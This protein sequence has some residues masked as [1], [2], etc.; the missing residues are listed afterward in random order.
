MASDASAIAAYAPTALDEITV[1][2]QTLQKTFRSNRTKDIDFRIQQLR[3]LYWGIHDNVP[4]LKEA[5]LRDLRKSHY[6]S[7]LTE[8]NWCL[9]ECLDQ[10]NNIHKWSKDEN[11]P[12][13]PLQ[14]R[15]MRPRMRSEP[16]GTILVIGAYNFPIQLN[17]CP[18]IGAI[19]AGNTVL[20]KPSELSPCTAMV[21]KKIFDESL[22]PECYACVNG[23][24]EVSK[25]IMEQKFSK[26]VFTGGKK[27]GA[28]IAQKAGETL[29]PVLLELGGQNPAFVTKNADIKIAARRLLWQ[30]CVSAGQL[31]L[32]QNYALVER[33]VVDE[34]IQALKDEVKVFMPQGT[35]ES[36]DLARI[37]NSS[38]FNRLKKMLDESKGKI[39]V[40]GSMDES[41]L[42]IEPTVVLVDSIEDSLMAD[43]TFGPIWS[44]LPFDSLDDAID[45][46]NTVDPTPLGLYTF[47]SDEENKKILYNVTSGGATVNDGLFHAMMNPSPLGGIGGSG[48][49]SYHGIFSF[50]AFSHQRA[51]AEVP[52]WAD[53]L[54]RVRYMPYD[55]KELKRHEAMS[56]GKPN[57]DRN[58]NV[59][60][61]LGY[62]VSFIV[63]LGAKK[64]SGGALRP[65]NDEQQQKQQHIE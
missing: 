45:I 26:I 29:T 64:A 36:P 20:L 13:I 19:A 16:L 32:S 7:A 57:F 51:I 25:H 30:K 14:Y 4:L 46:A 58:G 63:T 18:V 56:A 42:F 43:E 61:G 22:D 21:L 59:V 34:F 5:V 23:A 24:L 62:W 2:V 60:K 15:L 12:N 27:T 40:G 55:A 52:R 9:Q 1:N 53:K 48:Q 3:K 17:L 54:L 10:I 6:E 47:G 38:H 31:C 28:I 44:I 33:S 37:V 11:I 49:G 8:I 50:K 41:E 35:K 65:V 39:V